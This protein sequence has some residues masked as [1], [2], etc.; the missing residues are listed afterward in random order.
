LSR[1]F[2]ARGLKVAAGAICNAMRTRSGYRTLQ[3]Q[4]LDAELVASTARSRLCS[5]QAKPTIDW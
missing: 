2:A 5:M 3:H 4:R 1:Q